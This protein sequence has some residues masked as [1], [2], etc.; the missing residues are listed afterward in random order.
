MLGDFDTRERV[1][2]HLLWQIR[3]TSAEVVPES[4]HFVSVSTA[5]LSSSEVG[6]VSAKLEPPGAAE[7]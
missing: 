7:R 3:P 4:A 6:P 5:V 2:P 1:G